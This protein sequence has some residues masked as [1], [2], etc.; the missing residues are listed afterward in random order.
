[1]KKFMRRWLMPWLCG[2][3]CPKE[4][5][6]TTNNFGVSLYEAVIYSTSVEEP[7]RPVGGSYDFK[8]EKLIA[9][10]CWTASKPRGFSPLWV[11]RGLFQVIG[12]TGTD[13]TVK[14]SRPK[15]RK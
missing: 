9:P 13:T 1:M 10:L 6:S 5:V 3:C 15:K 2:K 4:K 12:D 7:P 8:R 14:W 11:S